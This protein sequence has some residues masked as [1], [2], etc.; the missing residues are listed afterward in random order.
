VKPLSARQQIKILGITSAVFFFLCVGFG[1]S[2]VTLK[3]QAKFAQEQIRVF[4]EMSNRALSANP[5]QAAECLNYVL[6][7]YP[8]GTKQE[9]GSALDQ[10]VEQQRERA[11]QEIITMLRVRTRDDLG[12]APESW[13]K[14]YGKVTK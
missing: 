1:W 2:N 12:R 11:I 3:L 6:T 13:I 7:Y 5:A 14:K 9:R 4:D 10:I 8:S